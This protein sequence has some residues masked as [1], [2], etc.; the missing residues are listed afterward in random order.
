MRYCERIESIIKSEE[1]RK[2]LESISDNFFNLKQE[3]PIRNYLVERYNEI[4]INSKAFAEYPREKNKRVDIS[5]ISNNKDITPFLLEIKFNY[6]K[7]SKFFSEFRYTLNDDFCE[8]RIESLKLSTSMFML[9]VANWDKEEMNGI[10][11]RFN[12]NHNLNNYISEKEPWKYNIEKLFLEESKKGHYYSNL[13]LRIN[14]PIEI[15]YSF[16]ILVRDN[17]LNFSDE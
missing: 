14:K 10:N 5:L 3:I 9:I 2:K 6:P 7:D 4:Y 17:H 1:F 12:I 13:T 15:F 16:F 8:N 11:K